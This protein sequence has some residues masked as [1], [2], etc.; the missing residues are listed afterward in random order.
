MTK[1]TLAEGVVHTLPADLKEAL[2]SINEVRDTWNGLTPLARNE[3][4]C[5][6]TTVKKAETR[7]EHIKRVPEEL[8][9]GMRRP[10]CWAGCMHRVKTG[11]A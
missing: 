7:R 3:W 10:C 4:I 1:N 6:V 5:W 11:K 2:L 8:I 9:A